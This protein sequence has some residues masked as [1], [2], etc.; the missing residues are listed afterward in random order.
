MAPFTQG[1][2]DLEREAADQRL[3]LLGEILVV[4]AAECADAASLSRFS[5]P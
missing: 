4:E 2:G 5:F 3:E 1:I